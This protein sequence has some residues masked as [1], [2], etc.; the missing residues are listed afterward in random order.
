MLIFFRMVFFLLGNLE[1]TS[2]LRLRFPGQI[3]SFRLPGRKEARRLVPGEKA[4]WAATGFEPSALN[5]IP[6]QFRMIH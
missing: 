5:Q 4:A 6:L 1:P 3:Q 2:T